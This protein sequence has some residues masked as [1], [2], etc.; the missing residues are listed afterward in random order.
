MISSICSVPTEKRMAS[1]V[2]PDAMRSSSLSCSCVVDHGWMARDL[3]SPTLARF[4]MILNPSTTWLPASAPPLTPNDS[5]PPNPRFRYFFAVSWL[6][7]LSNPG[8]DTHETFSFFSSHLAIAIALLACRSQRSD[9]VSR[10]SSNC[11]AANGFSALPRSRSTSM[12]TLVAKAAAPK[13]SHSFRP[14]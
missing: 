1:S 3:Q 14:W 9:K 6:G 2:T 11:C 8:Y 4:E 13:A 12:R 7:W 5:T 10:P